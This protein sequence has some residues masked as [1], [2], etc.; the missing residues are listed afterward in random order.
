MRWLLVIVLMFGFA[1]CELLD[2]I[3]AEQTGSGAVEGTGTDNNLSFTTMT[4]LL[5]NLPTDKAKEEII[6]ILR[7]KLVDEGAT[8]TEANEAVLKV[9][10]KLNDF[11][12]ATKNGTKWDALVKLFGL[13]VALYGLYKG[14]KGTTK[15]V[16]RLFK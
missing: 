14:G 3:I 9:D 8:D 6:K 10:G 11:I 16:A 7:K 1:K 2:Q 12:E 5:Q 4:N 15:L 13:M